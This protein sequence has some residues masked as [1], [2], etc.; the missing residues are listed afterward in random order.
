[1][2]SLNLPSLWLEIYQT[3]FHIKLALSGGS[4]VLV[5]CDFVENYV[6]S[7][8]MKNVLHEGSNVVI[9]II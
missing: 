8:T 6:E 1:M 9:I 4:T 7:D 2:N 3:K 5:L